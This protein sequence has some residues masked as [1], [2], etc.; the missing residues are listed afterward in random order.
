MVCVNRDLFCK[1]RPSESISPK[2]ELQNFVSVLGSRC[3]LRRPVLVL[4]DRDS[5]LGESG[6]PKR[7]HDEAC[8]KGSPKRGR[9]ETWCFSSLNPRPGEELCVLSELRA[10]PSEKSS[11][12]RDEVVQPLLHVRLGEVG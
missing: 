10:R 2:R 8:E 4:S 11:P 6:S 5:R 1:F 9:N 12:K 7:G 3:S